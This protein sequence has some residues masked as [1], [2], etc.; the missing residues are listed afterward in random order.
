MPYHQTTT[1]LGKKHL[2]TLAQGGS[3]HLK[4]T[5]VGKGEHTLF[6][7]Q[8]Q[9]SRLSKSGGGIQLSF[10]TPQLEHHLK[11]GGGIWDWIKSAGRYVINKGRKVAGLAVKGLGRLATRFAGNAAGTALAAEVPGLG[12]VVAPL[13]STGVQNV[14]NRG[15]DWLADKISGD[16]VKKS[17]KRKSESHK[18]SAKRHK[19]K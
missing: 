8:Q 5:H 15:V 4:P 6:L 19:S 2:L 9:L 12:A 18:A 11:F 14:G 16:G 17:G 10:S 3:V 1:S 7:T 13:V